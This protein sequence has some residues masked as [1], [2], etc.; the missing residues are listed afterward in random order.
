MRVLLYTGKGRR[1]QDEHQRCNCR[2][3]CRVGL[4][5]GRR[6]LTRAQQPGDSFDRPI[7]SQLTE[8][9][10]TCGVRRSTCSPRWINTGASAGLSQRRLHVAGHGQHGGRGTHSGMHGRTGQPHADHVDG[11]KRQLRRHHHRRGADGGPP[12]NCSAFPTS[13]AGISRKSSP[14]S[15]RQSNWRGLS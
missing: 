9:A 14:S 11:R 1:R 7:G 13:P 2:S 8:L 4:S 5:H 15:A 12:C 3:L 10:P 6:A